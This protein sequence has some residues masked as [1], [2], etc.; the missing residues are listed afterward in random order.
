MKKLNPAHVAAIAKTVNTC[1][2][3]TL[4]SMELK[5]FDLGESHL[6]VEVQQKHL[7]P[8]GIV[9][10]GVCASLADAAIYWAV[11]AGREE[12]VGLTTLELKLNYLAPVS[13][14]RMI[15]K[16]RSVKVGKSICLGEA[17]VEDDKGNLVAHGTSTLMVLDSL[18]IHGQSQLPPKFLD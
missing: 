16:G 14:G 3:F 17:S 2:Y 10:G 1:P 5:S 7:Q 9:H 11:Y 8:Y 18:K 12:T 15:A 6:E 4:L 13:A